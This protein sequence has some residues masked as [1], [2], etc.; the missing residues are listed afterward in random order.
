MGSLFSC[1]D[2]IPTVSCSSQNSHI[3]TCPMCNAFRGAHK[4]ALYGELGMRP[5]R[6]FHRPWPCGT[7]LKPLGFNTEQANRRIYGCSALCTCILRFLASLTTALQHL[8]FTTGVLIREQALKAEPD[9]VKALYRRAVVYRL[10]D[11]F[12]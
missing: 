9:N 3:S 11:Q 5:L 8:C 12:K 1:G 2:I 7:E 6:I 4:L 10:R